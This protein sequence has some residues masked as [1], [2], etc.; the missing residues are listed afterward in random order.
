[1]ESPGKAQPQEFSLRYFDHSKLGYD[2]M[3]GQ[4]IQAKSLEQAYHMAANWLINETQLSPSRHLE[5]HDCVPLEDTLEFP[6]KAQ[7][8]DI[9][10]QAFDRL[11]DM[12]KLVDNTLENMK[13]LPKPNR[14][15]AFV[16]LYHGGSFDDYPTARVIYAKDLDA[17][18]GK[19]A[20]ILIRCGDSHLQLCAVFPCT[21]P[22]GF[23]DEG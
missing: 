21:P 20:N 22:K 13:R 11:C 15:P 7:D 17:A 1:M 18:H 14:K 5:L 2:Q 6:H 19:A 9:L 4:S 10:D 16:M 12:E 8:Q 23:D 3:L